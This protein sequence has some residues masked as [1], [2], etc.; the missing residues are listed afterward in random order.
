[1]KTNI[2]RVLS[3][4]MCA[5][6]LAGVFGISTF[7]QDEKT[8][9]ASGYCG[10]QINGEVGENLT[11]S[12]Y[13]TKELVISG[14]GLMDWYLVSQKG[15][16]PQPWHD[17]LSEVETITVEEGV[18]SIGSYAFR[19]ED[20][21]AGID[22]LPLKRINIAKSVVNIYDNVFYDSAFGK[23]RPAIVYSASSNDWQKITKLVNTYDCGNDGWYIRKSLNVGNDPK[24]NALKMFYFGKAPESYCEIT[25]ADNYVVKGQT[26]NFA[27]DYYILGED[28]TLNWV[29]EGSGE[30][31][32]TVKDAYGVPKSAVVSGYDRGNSV[33]TVQIINAD[34][35]VVASDS[36]NITSAKIAKGDSIK[37]I[38]QKLFGAASNVSA[39]IQL[40]GVFSLMYIEAAIAKLVNAVVG[41]IR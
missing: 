11:W 33:L 8:V 29:L 37:T 2:A 41:L 4:I 15:Q 32:E 38:F 7:A 10:Q 34:G 3:L 26:Y 27:A 18:A 23:M 39:G 31:K 25:T 6:M 36:V 20:D 17:Y 16:K 12:Y 21:Y 28:E 40:S 24:F 30:I 9:V 19:L 5:V 14:T 22:T 13:D 35:T 1:M